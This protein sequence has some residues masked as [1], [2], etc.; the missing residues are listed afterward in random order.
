MPK[1]CRLI[2]A[3]DLA[4]D[5][6]EDRAGWHTTTRLKVPSDIT[7]IL[8]PFAPELNPMENVWQFVRQTWLSNRIF[9]SYDGIIGI[10]CWAWHQLTAQPHLIRSIGLRKWAHIGHS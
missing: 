6:I 9:E 4:A 5:L 7:V 3:C 1:R 8:L 10:G 2:V